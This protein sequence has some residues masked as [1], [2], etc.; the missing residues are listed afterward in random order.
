MAILLG[1]YFFLDF[2][3]TENGI[4]LDESEH[5]IMFG[6]LSTISFCIGMLFA[7]APLKGS[8]RYLKKLL[9]QPKTE[10]IRVEDVLLNQDNMRGEWIEL[11]DLVTKVERKL[12]RRTKAL[13]RETTELNAVMNSLGSPTVAITSSRGVSF[14]NSAFAVLFEID[15]E[16]IG[17][18]QTDQSLDQLIKEPAVVKLLE[19]ALKEEN[20]EKQMI[21]LNIGDRKR[22]F[23]I[24][25]SPLRRG[26]DNSLY[27][28]V[29]T[30]NDET[31]AVELDQ[32]RMDFVSNASHELRTPITAVSTSVS[33]LKR[34]TD[35]DTK[36]E[37]MESLE[38]NARRLVDL[39]ND[40]LDLSKFE[41]E[42]EELDFQIVDL[43]EVTTA[44]L[45]VLEASKLGHKKVDVVCE[46]ETGHFDV[47][48]V[49]QVL[50]NLIRNAR[51]YTPKDR[52]I[53][54]RWSLDAPQKNLI[55]RVKD[56][57]EG[58]PEAEHARIF[59]RFYRVDKS[60][61]RSSGGSGIG[62]SIVK[63]IMSLH[64]GE[65]MLEPYK[66][67]EGASFICVFP[68]TR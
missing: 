60:R 48:K 35:E 4:K 66:S 21:G 59:E 41:D 24:M 64:G 42:A 43:E 39:T 20:F 37:I 23:S 61:S 6:V 8:I 30:F 7:L 9:N 33:L 45:K 13:L 67:G 36:K 26:V 40:L 47:S 3:L 29:A 25:M 1:S 62:L 57:G 17:K 2:I 49:K 52:K 14:L 53:E 44:V 5:I 58:V 11:S 34:I 16:S 63:H 19:T 18:G 54:V 27:G 31:K 65:V 22:I 46:V 51:I 12:R 28:L 56:W 32:K 15:L 50:N 55:L 38:L 10:N 68:L